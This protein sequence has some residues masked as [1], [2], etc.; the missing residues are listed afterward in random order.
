V[1]EPLIP[2]KRRGVKPGNNREVISGILQLAS[3]DVVEIGSMPVP[4]L[5]RRV[6]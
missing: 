4:G 6:A 2:M 5:V 1:I 3:G